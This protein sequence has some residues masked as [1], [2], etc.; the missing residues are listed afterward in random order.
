MEP[1]SR[2]Q[3]LEK[4]SQGYEEGIAEYK[5]RD[6]ELSVNER[7]SRALARVL[8]FSGARKRRNSFFSSSDDERHDSRE[9][10]GSI[11]NNYN[12]RS[13]GV[14]CS[15]PVTCQEVYRAEYGELEEDSS[16]EE[17]AKSVA[18]LRSSFSQKVR[19]TGNKFTSLARTVS[20]QNLFHYRETGF[21]SPLAKQASDLAVAMTLVNNGAVAISH[22]L[23]DDTLSFMGQLSV[24]KLGSKSLTNEE[25]EQIRRLF[26]AILEVHYDPNDELRLLFAGAVYNHLANLSLGNSI[27]IVDGKLIQRFLSNHWHRMGQRE[28]HALFFALQ[29]PVFKAYLSFANMIAF[30]YDTFSACIAMSLLE[31]ESD[32][33]FASKIA[34]VHFARKDSR[35]FYNIEGHNSAELAD[36]LRH[37]NEDEVQSYARDFFNVTGA[38]EGDFY[39][40]EKLHLSQE[41]REILIQACQGKRDDVFDQFY[42]KLLNLEYKRLCREESL[43]TENGYLPRVEFERLFRIRISS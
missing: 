25:G 1:A 34:E 27:R 8:L 18:D 32:E 15:V 41:K 33:D 42:K 3:S 14:S 11:E 28:A 21:E 20:R 31:K 24:Y 39:S 5:G 38:L 30:S 37:F 2:A 13:I 29:V 7:T 36:H 19:T 43:E 10:T 23:R 6:S 12:L 35:L 4:I 40:C 16:E 9:S 17:S 22:K 26:Q